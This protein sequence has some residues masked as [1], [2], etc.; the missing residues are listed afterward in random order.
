MTNGCHLEPFPTMGPVSMSI[1]NIFMANYHRESS[2]LKLSIYPWLHE[3]RHV[4]VDGTYVPIAWCQAISDF[5]SLWLNDFGQTTFPTDAIHVLLILA[6]TS[7][8]VP[9]QTPLAETGKHWYHHA[10]AFIKG[11]ERGKPMSPDNLVETRQRLLKLGADDAVDLV[12]ELQFAEC[13]FCQCGRLGPEGR[14]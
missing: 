10:T 12:P 11:H 3:E 8:F 1:S 4:L 6:E 13:V 9:S 7:S 2:A 5:N 14:E